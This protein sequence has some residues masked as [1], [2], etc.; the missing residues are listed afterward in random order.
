MVSRDTLELQQDGV[1]TFASEGMRKKVHSKKKGSTDFG[2]DGFGVPSKKMGGIV[3][4]HGANGD[5]DEK[6]GGHNDK[7]ISP[8]KF[9]NTMTQSFRMDRTVD[10]LDLL[11]PDISRTTHKKTNKSLNT[12]GIGSNTGGKRRSSASVGEYRTEKTA[13]K[14]NPR[15]YLK[16]QDSLGH[17]MHSG[18]PTAPT[19]SRSDEL[20]H[21]FTDFG[22]FNTDS[23]EPRNAKNKVKP[24]GTGT[25]SSS[26]DW[27]SNVNTDNKTTM[28]GTDSFDPFK[29]KTDEVKKVQQKPPSDHF[30]NFGFDDDPFHESFGAFDS[31]NDKTKLNKKSGTKKKKPVCSNGK[32]KK[33][34]AC[35]E[36][37]SSSFDRS[38]NNNNAES[39]HKSLTT[40]QGD[41]KDEDVIGGDRRREYRN[42]NSRGLDSYTRPKK[43][44]PSERTGGASSET[45]KKTTKPKRTK[46]EPI[47]NGGFG[48][49]GFDF[50]TPPA[51]TQNKPA[52]NDDDSEEEEEDDIFDAQK[53]MTTTSNMPSRRM[54]AT[55][56]NTRDIRASISLPTASISSIGNGWMADM[57]GHIRN[58]RPPSPPSDDD[59]DEDGFDLTV[60]GAQSVS[61]LTVATRKVARPVISR[62]RY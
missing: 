55:A 38:T 16:R 36:K 39:T 47:K 1:L 49:S 52:E 54:S 5:D 44:P 28:N 8:T 40:R 4:E 27:F 13:S 24:P 26:N 34:T 57:P 62:R 33:S 43:L 3:E 41:D 2:M 10:D 60:Q 32:K 35:V 48:G 21:L 31:N 7:L 11:H 29:T 15:V 23:F 46:S 6:S 30:E 25:T 18:R 59:D 9:M 37:A 51:F 61:P 58:Q 22:K 14:L 20:A 50:E 45:K 12:L 53:F 56:A 17:S 19:Q 42:G